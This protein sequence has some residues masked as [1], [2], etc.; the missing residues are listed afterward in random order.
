MMAQSKTAAVYETLKN[1]L[2]DGV[3]K[4]EAKLAIDQVAERFGVN[5]G[6]VREALSRLTSDRLVVAQPQRGFTVAPV[7]AKDLLDL[8]SVR[9]EIETRCLRRSMELG[10]LEWEGRLLGTWHQLSR[11]QSAGEGAGNPE[12][13]R[14]HARFHDDLIGA[15]DSVWWLRLRESLFMQAE[16][17]RRMML[18]YVRATR[19]VEAEHREILDFTL[20]RNAGK[21][22]QALAAHLNLT[23]EIL[24]TSGRADDMGAPVCGVFREL[25]EA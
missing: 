16:R 4:P 8:T 12:W 25:L 5:A 20:S 19:D 10:T 22:C 7:S 3:H 24:I 15:C 14:L 1:E 2:L 9:I 13:A 17:Y 23:A 6:A 18:P 21:A 11:T